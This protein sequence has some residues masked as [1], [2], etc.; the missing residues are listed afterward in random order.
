MWFGRLRPL[1]YAY[2]NHDEQITLVGARSVTAYHEYIYI[3]V[4]PV[5]VRVIIHILNNYTVHHQ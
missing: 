1:P 4:L 3:C 2:Y 5:V